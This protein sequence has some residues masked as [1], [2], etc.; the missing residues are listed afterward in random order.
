MVPGAPKPIAVIPSG[1]NTCCERSIS[2]GVPVTVSII[3]P[4]NDVAGIRIQ[5]LPTGRP[6]AL[7]GLVR[8]GI[9]VFPSECPEHCPEIQDAGIPG[10]ARGVRQQMAQRDRADAWVHRTR[11]FGQTSSGVVSQ[12]MT[13]WSTSTPASVPVMAF[14]RHMPLIVDRGS[15]HRRE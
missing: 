10:H 15:D 14:V 1:A 8:P 2:Q 12:L 6:A 11:E 5:M 7:Q 4:C 9:D 13:D 3:A